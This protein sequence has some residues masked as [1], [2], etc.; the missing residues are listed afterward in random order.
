MMSWRIDNAFEIQY[1][2]PSF[3]NSRLNSSVQMTKHLLSDII[4]SI[5]CEMVV[6]CLN[7]VLSGKK[8]CSMYDTAGNVEGFMVIDNGS[9]SPVRNLESHKISSDSLIYIIL[10]CSS[11]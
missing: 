11:L 8:N 3:M 2:S 6:C 9:V 7:R 5:R 10:C 1:V 4:T